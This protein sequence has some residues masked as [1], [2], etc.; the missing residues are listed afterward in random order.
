[1]AQSTFANIAASQTDSA[2]V[3]AIAGRYI[4]VIGLATLTGATATTITFNSK[5]SGS[6]TAIS[7]L[8]AN[9]ANGGAV[10]PLA[11]GGRWWFQTNIGEALTATT[12][13]GSTTGV[14][15]VYEVQL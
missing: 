4:R 1:M 11:P 9:A 2:L 3:T 10:L 8:L 15:V 14:Q 13:S 6:G 5:G 7:M 12:G